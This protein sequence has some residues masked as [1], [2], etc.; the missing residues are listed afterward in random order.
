MCARIQWQLAHV[1]RILLFRLVRALQAV[2]IRDRRLSRHHTV[3]L[4]L[5]LSIVWYTPWLLSHADWRAA[6]LA[7]PFLFANGL[8]IVNLLVS[9]INSWQR[10]V[11]QLTPIEEGAEP[12]VAVIMPTSGEP[13]RMVMRTARSI[14]EQRWPNA[15]VYLVISDD[16]RS[17]K[18]RQAVKALRREYP[19]AEIAYFQPPK[20]GTTQRQGDAKAGNLNAALEH[21]L[22]MHRHI[23]FVETRDADDMVGDPEFLRQ[24]VGQ[25]LANDSVAFVQTVKDV[26]VS[27][28][29][30]FSNRE[31]LF[32]RAIMPARNAA[33][34]VFP[35]GSGLVWRTQA[36]MD[37]GGF[38]AWNLVEDLQSG[39]E[40]LRRGWR[41]VYLPI[42]GAIGQ[43]A[44]ED[45]PN[46]YKQRG[47]WALDTVR[48][49][50]W[51]D[52]RGLS[53]RQRLHF[54][55]L[56][57]FYLQ[58]FAVM[59]IL[60]TLSVSF[61][62]GAYPLVDSSLSYTLHFWPFALSV[63]LFLASLNDTAPYETFLKSRRLWVGMAPVYARACLQALVG[64]R[65]RKPV[66]RVTRKTTERAWYWREM[67]PQTALM[68]L[69]VMSLLFSLATTPLLTRFDV[70]SAYWAAIFLSFLGSF[71]TQAW[72]G[73]DLVE[74]AL[75]TVA[76]LAPTWA[77]AALTW[78]EALW[79]RAFVPRNKR[80]DHWRESWSTSEMAAIATNGSLHV[81]RRGR[82]DV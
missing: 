40:A 17:P 30:P 29:D 13:L 77:Q 49:L 7:I 82:E 70:G 24:C 47:V 36:L 14:L 2:K 21:I 42:V 68:A 16:A 22:Y 31:Q 4:A 5:I 19:R 66:Y 75:S 45:I 20:R 6:W 73:F 50:V 18:I 58:S 38:P 69:L 54:I 33:N 62:F 67:L 37:I 26:E 10:S 79:A 32:Y 11:P 61:L 9:V 65:F 43:H 60:L 15:R 1:L 53:L 28:G 76:R 51:G 80:A 57:L 3:S 35:C 48:L 78:S 12:T 56:G 46:V 55:E 52:L 63:E 23:Q 41:G 44:P 74:M 8:V 59:T 81:V 34:A 64:G 72:Y 25:L 39:V 71:I 27:A